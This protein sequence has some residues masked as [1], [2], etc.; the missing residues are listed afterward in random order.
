MGAAQVSVSR[1]PSPPHAKH[2]TDNFNFAAPTKNPSRFA[3]GCSVSNEYHQGAGF[4]L[5]RRS[6]N[7]EQV[8]RGLNALLLRHERDAWLHLQLCGERCCTSGPPP[9]A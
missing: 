9:L 3:D 6:G 1:R 8:A 7:G 2:R 5:P 4:L